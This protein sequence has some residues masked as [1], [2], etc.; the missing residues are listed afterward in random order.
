MRQILSQAKQSLIIYR[1][2]IAYGLLFSANAL[3]S[4]IVASF[5]NTNWSDLNRTSKFLVIVVIAQNWTGVL[6]AF[7]N[8]TLSRIE[9][10]QPPIQT[11]DTTQ[12]TQPK[13]PTP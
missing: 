7:L 6:L 11:G 10:G 1:L 13:P 9:S 5:L 2:A 4:A 3:F 8:K 12:F